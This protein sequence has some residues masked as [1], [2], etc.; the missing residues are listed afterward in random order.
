MYNTKNILFIGPYS[1][2]PKGGVAFVLSEYK[3]LFPDAYFVASNV[4]ANYFSKL[5]SLVLGLIR[6]I[7]LLFIHP[8]IRIVHIHSASR[9]S[10]KRK[11]IY[12]KIAK[13]FNKKVIV[14][15]HGG[16]FHEFYYNAKL[17][18][19]DKISDFINNSDTVVCLS[20]RWEKFFTEN[21]EPRHILTIPN[22][23]TTPTIKDIRLNEKG[24]VSFLFLGLIGTNKGIW[25]LLETLSNY[26]VHL[27][28]KAKFYLG[29]NGEIKK[30]QE[31]IRRYQLE[32]IVSFI[33]WVSNE[34]KQMYFNGA[35]IFILPSYNEGLPIS[36]LEAMSHSLPIISTRVGG[37]PDI[38]DNSNGILI[39]PGN[40]KQLYDAIKYFIGGNKNSINAMG[41][42]SFN[43]VEPYLPTQVES[44]LTNLYS[45][46]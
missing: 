46:L 5:I 12:F 30:L 16:M 35:D 8:C 14:H 7:F 41:N 40:Q 10:F 22:I 19:K 28:G 31:L 3:K 15:I 23:I 17:S 2:T 9:N 39:E 29:G 32:D 42:Q 18:L 26:K 27:K 25:F 20:S 24:I 21:F 4:P 36:I 1:K 6:F 38:V 45:K 13:K 33:G 37:I 44:C 43:K 34:D 11:Y